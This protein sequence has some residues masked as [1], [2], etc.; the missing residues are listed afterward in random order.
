VDSLTYIKNF[1]VD[2]YPYIANGYIQVNGDYVETQNANT[3]PDKTEEEVFLSDNPHKVFKGC[4]LNSAGIPLTP[5]FYRLGIDETKHYNEIINNIKFN[6]EQRRY[7]FIE[8]SFTGLTCQPE[9]NQE[10]IQP[11][12]LQFQYRFSDIAGQDKRFMLGVPLEEDLITG[13][14]T[15]RYYEVLDD[16]VET[17]GEVDGTQ[18]FKYIF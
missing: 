2:Y 18:T 10:N 12:G 8:G 14:C 13:N 16:T 11:I 4:L 1:N 5:E 3:Y 15:M 17:D 7:W 6:L 9:N